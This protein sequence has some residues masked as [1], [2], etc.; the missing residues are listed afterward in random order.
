MRRNLS[1]SGHLQL[2]TTTSVDL[3]CLEIGSG[4]HSSMLR[5]AMYMISPFLQ[6]SKQWHSLLEA[7]HPS[8]EF[9]EF[10]RGLPCLQSKDMLLSLTQC[11]KKFQ[12]RCSARDNEH[13]T[14]WCELMPFYCEPFHSIFPK[15]SRPTWLE[16][17]DLLPFPPALRRSS[18][19]SAFVAEYS[20][21]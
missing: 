11:A 14:C 6:A 15:I 13:A 20:A 10:V 5:T 8:E 21:T 18:S 7:E 9:S 2:R 1:G 12:D 4:T 16:R 3:R 17:H 19:P